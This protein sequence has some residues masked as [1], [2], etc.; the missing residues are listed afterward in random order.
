MAVQISDD[1]ALD[2]PVKNYTFCPPTKLKV[3][4]GWLQYMCRDGKRVELKGHCCNSP[5]CNPYGYNCVGGCRTFKSLEYCIDFCSYGPGDLKTCQ[6]NCKILLE[7]SEDAVDD[8]LFCCP[9]AI[10][11]GVKM[12]LS[13][14][15]AKVQGRETHCGS[16]S[17]T[18]VDC[19]CTDKCIPKSSD[20]VEKCNKNLASKEQ[21]PGPFPECTKLCVGACTMNGIAS[22]T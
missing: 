12:C 19:G 17:C 21:G 3:F 10:L 8:T 4:D 1:L 18:N 2:I 14:E 11:K 5:D 15:F 13:G 9:N 7:E 20:C 22:C 6:S 16:D